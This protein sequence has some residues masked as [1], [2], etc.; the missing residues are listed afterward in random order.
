[1]FVWKSCKNVKWCDNEFL[2]GANQ[3]IVWPVALAVDNHLKRLFKS[4]LVTSLPWG[5]KLFP[6]L[7]KLIWRYLSFLLLSWLKAIFFCLKFCFWPT[8]TSYTQ[9]FQIDIRLYYLCMFWF[10]FT[11][12]PLSVSWLKHETDSSRSFYNLCINYVS[13]RR[14]CPVTLALSVRVAGLVLILC[15]ALHSV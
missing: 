15:F 12:T 13:L 1:M 6:S 8:L 5:T 2:C 4:Y 7:H 10:Y 3:S 9:N 11:F 14:M